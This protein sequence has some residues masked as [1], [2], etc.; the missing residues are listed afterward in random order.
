MPSDC[1]ERHQ[2]AGLDERARGFNRVVEVCR[3]GQAYRAILKYEA[4]RVTTRDGESAQAALEVLIRDLHASGFTQLRSQL[5]FRGA[6]YLGNREP[7]VE[8]PDPARPVAMRTLFSRL[9]G[10]LRREQAAS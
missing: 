2:L 10:R 1:I 4:R 6:D 9:I 8:Y 5:S 7:W 3:T